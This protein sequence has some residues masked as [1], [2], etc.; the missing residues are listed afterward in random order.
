MDVNVVE[1]LHLVLIDPVFV[2]LLPAQYV[3]VVDHLALFLLLVTFLTSLDKAMHK[4]M[5]GINTT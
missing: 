5:A 3:V 4:A 2:D 1:F